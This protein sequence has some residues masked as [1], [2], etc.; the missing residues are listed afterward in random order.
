MQSEGKG[1]GHGRVVAERARW[2]LPT[3]A[4]IAL[5]K[6]ATSPPPPLSVRFTVSIR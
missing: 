3:G 4:L 2:T 1:N 5:C 6:V